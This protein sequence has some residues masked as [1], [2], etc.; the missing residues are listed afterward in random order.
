[1]E[2]VAQ[3]VSPKKRIFIRLI[4]TVLMLTTAI[5]VLMGCWQYY[6]AKKS[7]EED[8]NVG[9]DQAVQ[10]LSLT[11]Q[12]PLYNFDMGTVEA[13][14]RS[15]M[16]NHRLLSL[17]LYDSS[18][19]KSILVLIRD[20]EN[21]IRM[22]DALPDSRAFER[23]AILQR[24][25]D[26]L[27]SLTVL[28]DPDSFREHLQQVLVNTI[29]TIM[30]LN[31]LLLAVMAFS[32]KMMVFQPLTGMISAVRDMAEGEGDLTR[33]LSEERGDEL[34]LAAHW[35]NGF[36][37]QIHVIMGQIR[38]NGSTLK[39]SS[40]S[41]LSISEKM[42]GDA[43]GSAQRATAVA[44]ATG[45]MGHSMENV[46]S[47]ME[48][49]ASNTGM[50]A[51]A[52][53]EMTSTIDE[54]AR[55]AEEARQTTQKAVERS[56][57]AWEKMTELGG[58]AGEIG[59]VTESISEIS[60]QTNLLALNATIEAARAGEAGKGFAV[61]ATEI[62]HL[63]TQTVTATENIRTIIDAARSIIEQATGE[64][65][66]VSEAILAT[67][68]IVGGIATAVEE[69]SAA[70]R[71]I[72]GNVLQAA[73]GIQE[74]NKN[75]ASMNGFVRSIRQD[76]EAVDEISKK[77]YAVSDDVNGRARDVADMSAALQNLIGRFVL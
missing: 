54:I 47:A 56:E 29:I 69:Q 60:A 11:I 15:E 30:L 55:N 77:M 4:F 39:E 52:A 12:E 48:E 1:M 75:M 63:A 31:V 18:G 57:G 13:I 74:V 40:A 49:A 67:S 27:G 65:K 19:E 32:L 36:I 6:D 7:L 59:K 14:L 34:S 28:M 51:A 66:Q 9:A 62:K 16:Q 53:E 23:R 72:S 42:A 3:A 68:D 2:S 50:V 46:V 5:L 35:I 43:R 64:V 61:V 70:T 41:L 24:D 38:E 20:G 26:V 45:D 8:L 10:R 73:Q 44:T 21:E 71:E 17:A 22:A 25:E 37:S 76:I 33:R 58:I